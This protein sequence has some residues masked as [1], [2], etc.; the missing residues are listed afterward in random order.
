MSA[1][2]IPKTE[3]KF[4]RKKVDFKSLYCDVC[5][6]NLCKWMFVKLGIT[7][8]DDPKCFEYIKLKYC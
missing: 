3:P 5:H 7:I 1:I 4:R 2:R 6:K 8:C